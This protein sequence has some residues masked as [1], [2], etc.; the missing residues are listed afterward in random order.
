MSSLLQGVGEEL[1]VGERRELDPG[2]GGHAAHGV[3]L[4]QRD[5]RRSRVPAEG[6]RVP[7]AVTTIYE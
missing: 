1:R 2:G 5:H 7:C 4:P 6:V 3:R